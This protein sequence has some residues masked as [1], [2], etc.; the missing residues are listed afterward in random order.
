M[1]HLSG[2]LVRQEIHAAPP[3]Q[4]PPGESLGAGA[5]TDGDTVGKRIAEDLH[6]CHRRERRPAERVKSDE[7]PE[8]IQ[9]RAGRRL[10]AAAGGFLPDHVG[11]EVGRAKYLVENAARTMHLR[12]VQVEPYGTILR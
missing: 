2:L 11:D 3:F 7:I 4:H 8:V 9:P 1:R 6:L 10:E 12:V 5:A